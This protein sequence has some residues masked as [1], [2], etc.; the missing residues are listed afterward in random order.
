V[1]HGPAGASVLGGLVTLLLPEPSGRS[2]ED[3]SADHDA[4]VVPDLLTADLAKL[5]EPS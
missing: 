4:P 1:F 5:A 3:I 2:L